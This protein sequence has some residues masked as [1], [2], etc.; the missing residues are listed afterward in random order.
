MKQFYN[1]TGIEEKWQ[2]YWEKNNIFYAEDF[3]NKPKYYILDMFPYPSSS[4]LHVGHIEGYT[5]TDI[6]ARFKRMNGF[7]VLH[8]IGWD[9]FGLPAEQYALETGI[10]PKITTA[11]NI[12]NFKKQIKS[13]GFSY[14]W[15]REINTT[16]EKY[17]RWTQWI[18]I[19][20]YESGLAYMDTISVNW[21]PKLGTVLANEEVINGKSERGGYEVVQRPMKQWLLKITEYAERL[22][23]DLEDLD[24]PDNIKEMQRNWIGRSTG[25]NIKFK[26]SGLDNFLEVYTTRPETIFGVAAL[27]VAIG[28][29]IIDKIKE[30]EN[31]NK[32]DI[33]NFLLKENNNSDN[34]DKTG[35]FTGL[36]AINP[37]NKDKIPIWISNY[38]ILNKGT[39]AVMSVPSHDTRDFDFANNFSIPFN[40]IIKP[41]NIED[42]DLKEI[43]CGK[44]CWENN[45]TIVNS[46]NSNIDVN[47]RESILVKNI[48]IDWIENNNYGNRCTHYKIKDW[49]FSRQ[50]YWGEPFPIIHYNN[51]IRTIPEQDLPVTLPKIDMKDL[52]YSDD[53]CV[54]PLSRIKDWEYV[55]KDT[56]EHMQ[57]ETNTMPQW[58]GSCWYYLRYL[59]VNNVNE[60]C[61]LKK[62]QYWMPVD[63]YLGGSEHAVLHLLYARFW[64][65]VL[66]D[67][68]YVSTKEPFK[69][70]VNQGIILNTSYKNSN[71][72]I[73]PKEQV[74]FKNGNFYDK[75]TGEELI[76]FTTKMSKSLK[77]V[78][79][80]DEII[81][82]YGADSIRLYEMFMGP[83]RAAKLWDSN[84]IIGMYR[85][86][87]KV[88]NM[89][90][91]YKIEN[92]EM[93]SKQLYIIHSLIKNVTYDTENFNFNTAISDMII[94]LNNFV[95][96]IKDNVIPKNI[97]VNFIKLLS[98]YAPHISEE[99]WEYLGNDES[100]IFSEWPK[101]NDVYLVQKSVKI[102]IQV[103][104]KLKLVL[105][106]PFGISKEELL[107]I[108][109]DNQKISKIVYSKRIKKVIYIENRLLNIVI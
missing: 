92:I 97:M 11:Q 82:K 45:G 26:I 34:Y 102:P 100:I 69:K 12:S 85:F 83:I 51:S 52:K 63:L 96:T 47:G 86:L 56:K 48:V 58:A 49:L 77:N 32:L 18:F 95:D 30:H 5:A 62:E 37:I 99:I 76:Q 73:I 89:T 106:C 93:T 61:E 90:Y 8:P 57:L 4:G 108:S 15:S 33:D 107:K 53:D 71:E 40:C 105:D 46:E 3:S 70:L 55:D 44:K 72:H 19:K 60:I 38:V 68:G 2:N 29:P 41:N 21:C 23:E 104:G 28:H 94:F 109:L 87:K 79:N 74:V 14:D 98:P 22:L 66:Y 101:Y 9:A 35:V 42:S 50:R 13:H 10:H 59:D 43:L 65:K 91:N 1:F 54:S 6:I 17:Y 16:D 24:W 31:F 80:P 67:L 84:G 27:I 78:V 75:S 39:G 25:L 36:Y 64:H 7:N 103:C 81:E 88:W 20:L